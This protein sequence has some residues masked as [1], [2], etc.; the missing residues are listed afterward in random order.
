MAAMMSRPRSWQ[1]STL[2]MP[3]CNH[4]VGCGL[5]GWAV[6]WLHKCARTACDA[7]KLTLRL[8]PACLHLVGGECAMQLIG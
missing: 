6:R 5:C 7:C 2:L 1:A 3:W 4:V 8:L